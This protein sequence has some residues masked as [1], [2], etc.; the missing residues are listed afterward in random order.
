MNS[1]RSWDGELSTADVVSQIERG[2]NVVSYG[3][4]GAQDAKVYVNQ[5]G[6]R[7]FIESR[8]DSTTLNNLLSQPE[9]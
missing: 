2:V 7:K 3:R 4:G 6:N 8:A 1:Y 5:I 9:F